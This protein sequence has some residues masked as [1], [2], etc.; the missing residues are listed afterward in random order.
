[1]ETALRKRREY[2]HVGSRATSLLRSVPQS[3]LHGHTPVASN[4][5]GI[6]PKKV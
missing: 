2:V 1:M 3:S 5:F 6:K 4:H